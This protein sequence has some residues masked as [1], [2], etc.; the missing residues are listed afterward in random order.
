M[1]QAIP[2]VSIGTILGAPFLA[3]KG[4]V[5]FAPLESVFLRALL[6]LAVLGS[7]QTGPLNACLA[8]LA[9]ATLLTERN[10]EILTQMP[11]QMPHWPNNSQ[12]VPVKAAPR[13]SVTEEMPY[14]ATEEGGLAVVES[15]GETTA[16]HEY[17]ETKDLQDN[18]PRLDQAP[19]ADGAPSFYANRSLSFQPNQTNKAP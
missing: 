13:S 3:Q 2:L 18:I 14:E 1:E 12:G 10:H 4:W 5:T 6:V 15:H 9:V 11:N 19:E 16:T 7:L 8:F 17:E